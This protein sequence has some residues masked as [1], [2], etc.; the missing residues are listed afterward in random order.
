MPEREK[1]KKSRFRQ[2]SSFT[3]KVTGINH[4]LGLL[5]FVSQTKM[6][7][8]ESGK[9]VRGYLKAN[10]WDSPS[11]LQIFTLKPEDEPRPGMD[12]I[13]LSGAQKSARTKWEL[14]TMAKAVGRPVAIY[15]K[16][17]NRSMGHFASVSVDV[18]IT[19]AL[20]IPVHIIYNERVSLWHARLGH[21]SPP[22][23]RSLIP[24][25]FS[26]SDHIYFQC[27]T[28]QLS[29]PKHCRTFFPSSSNKKSQ[30]PFY[31]IHSDV[32]GPAPVISVFGY[33]FFLS[34]I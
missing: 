7:W 31:I 6:I 28:C 20:H 33:R 21:S 19:T 32:W 24:T 23:L 4:L 26:S 22:I 2:K 30:I 34:F 27:E 10:W 1:R 5:R 11:G 13:P 18:D 29:K 9:A 15:L 12:Q 25:F 16:T 14:L 8:L 17:R 3:L